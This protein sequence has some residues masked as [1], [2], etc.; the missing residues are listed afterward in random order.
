MPADWDAALFP[1][2]A[3]LYRNV[4]GQTATGAPKP[5]LAL[6]RQGVPCAVQDAR[7]TDVMV[8]QAVQGKVMTLVYFP[9]DPGLRTDDRIKVPAANRSLIVTRSIDEA[10]A[11]QLWCAYCVDGG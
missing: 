1:D 4:P 9:A 10:G 2:L 3:D 6:Y 11:G 5:Y 7:P 8:S